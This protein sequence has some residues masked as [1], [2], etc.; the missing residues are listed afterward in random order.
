[1]QLHAVIAVAT[2]FT[3]VIGIAAQAATHQQPSQDYSHSHLFLPIIDSS[4]KP[5]AR[6]EIHTFFAQTNRKQYSLFLQ[7]FE[8]VKNGLDERDPRSLTAIATIHGEP[9]NYAYDGFPGVKGDGMMGNAPGYCKHG[10]PLFPVWHRPYIGLIERVIIDV[11]KNVIAPMYKNNTQEWTSV[12][13]TIRFPYYDWASDASLLDPCPQIF[14]NAY[15]EIAAPPLGLSKRIKNPFTSFTIPNATFN[16]FP[17]RLRKKGRTTFRKRCITPRLVAQSR[18]QVRL[19]FDPYLSANWSDFS[20]HNTN[21]TRDKDDTDPRNFH[22]LEHI[23]D[24]VHGAIGGFMGDP[25]IASY[26]PVFYF[27]HCNVDRMLALYQAT[28]GGFPDAETASI[29]LTPFRIRNNSNTAWTSNDAKTTESLGYT[30]PELESG[31]RGAQLQTL[32]LQQYSFIDPSKFPGVQTVQK[33]QPIVWYQ[34]AKAYLHAAMQTL[35]FPDSFQLSPSTIPSRKQKHAYTAVFAHFF[36]D[37]N[38]LNGAFELQFHVA[39]NYA[40]MA[41]VFAMSTDKPTN[42]NSMKMMTMGG[43]AVLTHAFLEAGLLHSEPRDWKKHVTVEIIDENGNRVAVEKVPSLKIH[44]RGF[45]EGGCGI[46]VFGMMQGAWDVEVV[47]LYL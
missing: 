2:L 8:H 36:V 16:K 10:D 47:N 25:S 35:S 31:L 29:P 14:T 27:H 6:Q 19:L 41:Y 20:N 39:G 26:D 5:I 12:A 46:G 18:D 44:L 1:M 45:C 38:A 3:A 11:A 43:N 23:H 40:A 21:R 42:K 9:R 34:T 17:K 13:E 37:M 33:Q 22:S 4:V 24:N 28:V 15:M 32:L 7:A 30:Y